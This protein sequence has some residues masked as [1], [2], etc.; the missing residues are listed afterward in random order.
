M[1]GYESDGAGV[2]LNKRVWNG[3]TLGYALVDP[4]T[5]LK[6][7]ITQ[8]ETTRPDE[9]IRGGDLP[10]TELSRVL[11]GNK[12]IGARSGADFSSTFSVLIGMIY[13]ASSNNAKLVYDR[14]QAL[15][16]LSWTQP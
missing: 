4:R 3:M 13:S 7:A 2:K 9:L 11:P 14:G 1:E 5:S 10:M 16:V 6:R 12:K 8:A 15:L